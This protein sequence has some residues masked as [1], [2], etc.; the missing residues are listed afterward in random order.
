[1]KLPKH[2]ISA[3]KNNKTSLGNHPSFPPEEED[4][5]L[6]SILT[7][8]FEKFSEN[9]NDENSIKE[10]LSDFMSKCKKIERENVNA[11][12][13]LSISVINKLFEIPQDT[14]KID[15]DIVDKIDAKQ[16]RLIPEKTVDYTFDNI[17]DM[18][19]LTDEVYKRRLLNCLVSGA[20]IYYS[21]NYDLYVQELFKINP[22]LPSLYKKVYDI[23]NILLYTNQEIQYDNNGGGNVEVH[24]SSNENQT[25]IKAQGLFFI[26]LVEET[27]KG[28]LELAIS[29]GLP[30]E[31]RKAEYVIGKSDFKLAEVW[32]MRIGLPLWSLIDETINELG[33]DTIEVGLNHIFM[34]IS[35][36]KVEDFNNVM[37]EIL[38]RTNKGKQL[39][40]NLCEYIIKNKEKDTFNDYISQRTQNNF[41][42]SDSI[43]YTVDELRST[44]Q[45][46]FEN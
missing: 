33:Y 41:Q 17:N 37:C 20:S 19:Q 45:R 27:I 11:L 30:Q 4:V 5:F 25:L 36:L 7:P 29:H 28:L 44:F 2:I 21:S 14:I 43:Y 18:R 38:G 35:M 16:E 3:I 9:Y 15:M 10:E 12:Q 23:N 22:E 13:E 26:T 40:K 1:M 6:L 31:R 24:I 34:E 8:F 42:L 32:D 46:I 39:L